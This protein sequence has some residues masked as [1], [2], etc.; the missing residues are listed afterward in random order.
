MEKSSTLVEVNSNNKNENTNSYIENWHLKTNNGR[1]VWEFKKPHD[2]DPKKLSEAFIF[3]KSI[4]PNSSDRIYRQ[5]CEKDNFQS[6]ESI[7]QSDAEESDSSPVF[8]SII[9]AVNFYK[10]LQT[11]DGN[12]TG[13]YGGPMFLLPGLVI[14]S[15]ITNT[16]FPREHTELI[17]RYM[18]NHQNDDGGWGLHI[19]GQSTMFG[20]VM[21][22]VSLRLLGM[23]SE[24][25]NLT[26]ARDWILK[27]KGA[28]CIPP[29]GKFYLSVLGA[30]EWEGNDSLLPEMWLL[31]KSLPVHPSRY[32]CHSRMVYLPMAYCYGARVTGTIT[33]LVKAL[34]TELYIEDYQSINWKN[35][36]NLICETDLYSKPSTGFEWLNK[37]IINPYE[38]IHNKTLRKKA[39][40]F[41]LEYINA[42]DEQTNYV[43]I[44]PV[45]Q[46]I[47]SICVWHAYGKESNQFKKHVNRWYDYLWVAEDGMKMN[48]YNGSQLWDTAFA[49]QALLES[50]IENTFPDVVNKAYHYIDITQVQEDV[51][52]RT[53]F[54]RHISKGGWPFSTLDHG[55][56]ISDCTAEGLSTV[57]HVHKSSNLELT[58]KIS[59]Q[60]LFDAVNVIL[61]F[62]NKNGGWATYENTRSQP[63]IEVLNPSGI[64]GDIMID[65]SYTECTSAC[66]RSLSEFKEQYPEHRKNE[67]TTAIES[68]ARFIKKQQMTDG[69]WYGS[70]AVCF[71]YGTWFG[72]EGLIAS[73]EPTY[74]SEEGNASPAIQKACDFLIARQNE[75][76]GWGE[77]FESC[78][79]KEYI[80]SDNSQV[81]NTSWALLTLM[82]ASYPNRTPIDKGI[83]FL[84]AKQQANGDWDQENISGVFNANCMITYTA[85]R[86]V[87]PIWALGRYY[88]LF[89]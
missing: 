88:K 82:A 11:E 22:Y 3:D 46:V 26:K 41:I 70:W 15:Y 9:N 6:V 63:W 74:T 59:D 54:F 51:K 10:C 33:D 8:K 55:W 85:Y 4:N 39:Q 56:P 72:V 13:D 37:F 48:G 31:P 75:D 73:G 40:N 38:A 78:V 36:R 79:E 77:S 66:I 32:W 45:N 65:Y 24:N 80:P 16:P 2:F 62:Q 29:W 89:K 12:W 17:K 25:N 57:L 53:K 87:L 68:G 7:N 58:N 27:R 84:I 21:Q 86:N 35:C 14:T 30:Y 81:V 42:E 28:Q 47:N 50:G 34:R 20:T 19:E 61:S 23:S 52:D 60:R 5:K 64:F 69:S 43:D 71:T 76:G 18:L 83:Q 1:Q 44:G 49:T 67:I